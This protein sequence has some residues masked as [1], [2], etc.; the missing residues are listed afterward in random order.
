MA[1]TDRFPSWGETGTLPAA[2][3]FYEGGDQVNEK[4]LDALW[5]NLDQFED[6]VIAQAIVRD[7]STAFTADIPAGG[8]GI[9]GI[10]A[11]IADD[12]P[13]VIYDYG[14][15]W[16]PL[17]ILEADTV[18]VA[19]NAVTLGGSTAIAHGDL[20]SIGSADHH[21][22]Y[23]D[24]E[25]QDAVGTILDSDFVYDD[26]GNLISLASTIGVDISGD[27]DTVDSKHADDLNADALAHDFVMGSV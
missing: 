14:N 21:A 8:N 19:G 18:T 16:V 12:V 17:S 13:N 5:H 11:D 9:T 7:G 10:G 2:G 22:K 24:E 25:A 23:T 26:A 27:A 3:F 1:L 20:T 4:H 6:E 15:K